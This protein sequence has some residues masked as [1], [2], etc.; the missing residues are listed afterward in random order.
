MNQLG[1]FSPH[2]DSFLLTFSSVLFVNYQSFNM[3]VHTSRTS[4]LN[5][6][7]INLASIFLNRLSLSI[8]KR[9]C[10]SKIFHLDDPQAVLE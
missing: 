3:H 8:T 2:L 7:T 1:V 10:R 6:T 9:L 4:S 5:L